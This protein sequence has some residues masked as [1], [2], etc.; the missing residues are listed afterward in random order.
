MAKAGKNKGGKTKS[1]R[2]W[3]AANTVAA[4]AAAEVRPGHEHL[5]E[6]ARDWQP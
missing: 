2:G 6:E 1:S 5:N 3:S 4:I